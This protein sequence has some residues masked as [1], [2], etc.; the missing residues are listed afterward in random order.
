MTVAKLHLGRGFWCFRSC[1][2]PVDWLDLKFDVL[3]ARCAASW[4]GKDSF[5]AVVDKG[6]MDALAC[7]DAEEGLGLQAVM[8]T[9]RQVRL[10]VMLTANEYPYNARKSSVVS[11]LNLLLANKFHA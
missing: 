4:F 3:D 2:D 7:I 9:A 8:D 1:D 11:T 6:T 10:T 5:D